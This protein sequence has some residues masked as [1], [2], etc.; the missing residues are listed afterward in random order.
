MALRKKGLSVMVATSL[1]IAITVFAAAVV[2]TFIVPWVQRN[3]QSS[4][5]CTNYDDYFRFEESLGALCYQDKK[6]YLVLGAKNDRQ[7]AENVVGFAL[8]LQ[9]IAA[10]GG[11][12]GQSKS[13]SVKKGEAEIA[14]M[15]MYDGTTKIVVPAAGES[16]TYVYDDGTQYDNAE[17]R[18]IV[19]NG[20]VC[21]KRSD[22]IKLRACGNT[23]R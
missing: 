8:T 19:G 12:G 1:I 5:E 10:P 7:L 16:H 14:N 11:A 17:I 15:K 13:I 18:A 23:R 4:T 9:K 20:R 21:D 6:H 22:T 3:L 2:G